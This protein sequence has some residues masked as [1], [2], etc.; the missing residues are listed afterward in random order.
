MEIPRRTFLRFTL[1]TA[2]TYPTRP[3]TMIV[4]LAAG[5]GVDA[6]ARVLAEGMRKP[7]GEPVIIENV[8]GANGTIGVGRTARAMP[9]GYT[10]DFGSISTHVLNGAFYSLRY[11]L[12]DDLVPIAA[13]GT[14][15][16]LLIASKTVPAN[17]LRELIDW[18]KAN[19]NKASAGVSL[20][21]AHLLNYALQKE[22]GTRFALVPYRGNAPAMQDLLAGQIDLLFDGIAQLPLLRAGKIKVY[23]VTTDTRFSTA[24]DIP[25]FSELGLPAL[26]FSSWVALFAP[27]RTPRDIIS[28]LNAAVMEALSDP[29]V[30]SRLLDLGIGFSK[31]ATDSASPRCNAKS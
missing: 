2:Q 19:P 17:D 31:R 23:A 26:S 7:L 30:R 28:K 11:D 25:T 10:I 21:A 22:T 3:V 29:I 14:S 16:W 1:A 4:P 6:M 24:P 8:S 12:L 20:G 13:V 27:K 9:D 18:L 5:G 15:P